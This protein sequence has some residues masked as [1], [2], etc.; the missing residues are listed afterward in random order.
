M[1][2]YLHVKLWNPFESKHVFEPQRLIMSKPTGTFVVGFNVY[3]QENIFKSSR[4][5]DWALYVQKLLND[6]H[7]SGYEQW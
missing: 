1:Y 2:M 7:F 4:Y 5:L 3:G 6:L